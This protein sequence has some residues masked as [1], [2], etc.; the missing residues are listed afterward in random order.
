MTEVRGAVCGVMWL[1]IG[2]LG[3]VVILTRA[4]IVEVCFV[5]LAPVRSFYF[6]R[7]HLTCATCSTLVYSTQCTFA[8]SLVYNLEKVV[9]V[10]FSEFLSVSVTFF[11]SFWFCERI[12]KVRLIQ[13][14]RV[15]S[16]LIKLLLH[17][18]FFMCEYK[19]IMVGH[20]DRIR[21]WGNKYTYRCTLTVPIRFATRFSSYSP[22]TTLATSQHTAQ[23][24]HKTL[25]RIC[26]RR[27]EEAAPGRRRLSL[28]VQFAPRRLG[29]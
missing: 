26:S 8:C 25:S 1:V 16:V 7:I 4:I 11:A 10:L 18:D 5:V 21:C 22:Q 20:R 24:S 17:V 2:L 23:Y 29:L 3:E 27:C 14:R 15:V 6:M 28:V 13:I 12:V 9:L 19:S